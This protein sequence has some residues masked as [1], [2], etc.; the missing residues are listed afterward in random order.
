VSTAVDT[1][2]AGGLGDSLVGA[3]G[4]AGKAAGQKR[5]VLVATPGVADG[6]VPPLIV[7]PSITDTKD[8]YTLAGGSNLGT[9]AKVR[10]EPREPREHSDVPLPGT[11]GS[12][13][14][15]GTGFQLTP[16]QLELARARGIP[17]SQYYRFDPNWWLAGWRNGGRPPDGWIWNTWTAEQQ[18]LFGGDEGWHERKKTFQSKVGERHNYL[19]QQIQNLMGQGM[20]AQQAMQQ[21]G[22]GRSYQR[23]Y[24]L[25][26]QGLLNA[27]WLYNPGSGTKVNIFTSDPSGMIPVPMTAADWA[28]YRAQRQGQGS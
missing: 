27:P 17:E 12:T 18:A 23:G 6:Q 3:A 1:S 8:K 16:A 13:G 28:W 22:A 26:S 15:S 19:W 5:Q 24:H 21:L 2:Q 11:D 14:T 25:W 10:G 9:Q 20:S 4:S 7:P